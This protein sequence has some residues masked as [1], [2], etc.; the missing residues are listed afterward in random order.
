MVISDTAVGI[1][2]VPE[3]QLD[4]RGTVRFDNAYIENIFSPSLLGHQAFFGGGSVS[5]D[6]STTRLRWSSDIL[7]IPNH[8]SNGSASMHCRIR[9]P[10]NGE[11]INYYN[12]AGAHSMHT[13]N[14]DGIALAGWQSLWYTIPDD[15][16]VT[17]IPSQFFKMDYY[18]PRFPVLGTNSILIAVRYADGI[19]NE[20]YFPSIRGRINV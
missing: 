15:G 18:S 8:H 3:V 17:S 10:A 11:E 13:V 9:C 16:P 5:Y 4:V 19:D 2:K 14:S 1:G 20:L 12:P 6:V 7:I